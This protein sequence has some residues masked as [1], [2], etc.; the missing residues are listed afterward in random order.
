MTENEEKQRQILRERQA[1]R[2]ESAWMALALNKDL[3]TVLV[4]LQFEFRSFYPSFLPSD[5]YNPH[6]AALRDGNKHVLNE[7]LRR[8]A[9]AK[10]R[11][12][13]DSAPRQTTA[14][15]AFRGDGTPQV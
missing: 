3:N 13:K 8:L 5:N 7:I 10:S 6:A 2:V 15:M 14:T 12:E 1:A 9:E 4:A 11:L